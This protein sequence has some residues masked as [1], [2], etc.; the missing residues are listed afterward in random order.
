MKKLI[1]WAVFVLLLACGICSIY[2]F[3]LSGN[4]VWIA[5]IFSSVMLINFHLNKD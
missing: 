5:L 3:A 4:P 1:Y 2:A